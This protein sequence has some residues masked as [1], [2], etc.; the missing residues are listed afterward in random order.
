MYKNKVYLR[1]LDQVQ[2]SII[3]Q[4]LAGRDRLLTDGYIYFNFDYVLD[5]EV[6]LFIQVEDN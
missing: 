4:H 3:Y 2:V 6:F 5:E 1:A